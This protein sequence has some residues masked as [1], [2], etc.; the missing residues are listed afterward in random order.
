MLDGRFGRSV[1][2]ERWSYTVEL[3]DGI[4]WTMGDS[5]LFAMVVGKN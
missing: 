5:R 4:G 2:A 3:M 1:V